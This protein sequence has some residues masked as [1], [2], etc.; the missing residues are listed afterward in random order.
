MSDQGIYF[1]LWCSSADDPD[2]ANLDIA[3]F[4]R[5]AKLGAY[6]KRH[7]AGGVLRLTAPAKL[8]CTILQVESFKALISVI[9]RMPKVSVE[10]NVAGVTTAIVTFDNWSRFQGDNSTERVREHR[11]R[12]TAN[13]IVEKSI[14]ETPLPP[15]SDRPENCSECDAILNGPA[16]LNTVLG[17]QYRPVG[18]GGRF[19]HARHKEHGVEEVARVVA[20]M[21]GRWRGQT[22]TDHNTGDLVNQEEYLTPAT[23][24]R[25]GN[26]DRYRNWKPP[27]S[28]NAAEDLE[29]K[30]SIGSYGRLK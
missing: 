13:S 29:R 17:R 9:R 30:N 23:L 21:I 2:L 27:T 3:D 18:E 4:G 25:P 28:K 5:W 10:V 6:T 20:V 15:V 12:V 26:F 7:G 19:L 16:G 8:V 11:R 1:K 14:V 24:F 22:W